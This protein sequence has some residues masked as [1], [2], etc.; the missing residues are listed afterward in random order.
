MRIKVT[1]ETEV[2]SGI[3]DDY[4]EEGG[5]DE[6]INEWLANTFPNFDSSWEVLSFPN[7]R[8]EGS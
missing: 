2:P 5:D 8:C 7:R 6:V 4:V 3:V 1:F